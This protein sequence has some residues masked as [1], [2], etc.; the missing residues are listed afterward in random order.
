VDIAIALGLVLIIAA[1]AVPFARREN[2]RR[3]QWFVDAR[4]ALGESFAEL[5]R[6][7]G[8]DALESEGRVDGAP[9]RFVSDATATQVRLDVALPLTV[10]EADRGKVFEL[11]VR[12]GKGSFETGRKGVVASYDDDTRMLIVR[13]RAS[14]DARETVDALV[15]E[16]TAMRL[17][18]PEL[19]QEHEAARHATKVRVFG[20]QTDVDG[21]HTRL[22]IGLALDLAEWEITRD[23]PELVEWERVPP[24]DTATLP[25]ELRF[26][27]LPQDDALADAG[28]RARLVARIA[29]ELATRLPDESFAGPPPEPESVPM[30]MLGGFPTITS[31]LDYERQVMQD[32]EKCTRE[33]YR[34]VVSAVFAPWAVL[35]LDLSAPRGEAA[36]RFA[37][38][39]AGATLKEPVGRG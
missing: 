21:R 22:G 5:R 10:S 27:G 32:E 9:A 23:G 12:D 11:L 30:E 20:A 31:Y 39:V 2:A 6:V 26:F 37:T 15:Q 25:C 1:I 14:R 35:V 24:E 7:D 16:A 33:P 17:R 4:A 36:K 8:V 29:S 3:R 28:A 13:T 19:I 18:L 38:I 34:Y